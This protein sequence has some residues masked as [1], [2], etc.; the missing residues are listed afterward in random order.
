MGFRLGT[1]DAAA[2]SYKVVDNIDSD[3][4]FDEEDYSA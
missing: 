4:I 1:C 2:A 3:D